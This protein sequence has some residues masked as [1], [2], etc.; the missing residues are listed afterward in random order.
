MLHREGTLITHRTVS[1][2]G[3]KTTDRIGIEA[4]LARIAG[5]YPPY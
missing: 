2:K 5:H 4:A 3:M 1:V